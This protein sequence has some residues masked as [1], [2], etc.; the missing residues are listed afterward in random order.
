MSRSTQPIDMMQPSSSTDIEAGNLVTNAKRQRLE[1]IPVDLDTKSAA[2]S[3]D[4]SQIQRVALISTPDHVDHNVDEVCRLLWSNFHPG[5]LPS[6]ILCALIR[7]PCPDQMTCS[8]RWQ[9]SSSHRRRERDGPLLS[10]TAFWRHWISMAVSGNAYRPM[11]EPRV[12]SRCE[13]TVITISQR[14]RGRM[15]RLQLLTKRT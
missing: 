10:T 13:H 11:S 1:D 2:T 8:L 7:S 15:L 9:Q 6:T 3:D 12:L 4:D 14:W 5:L